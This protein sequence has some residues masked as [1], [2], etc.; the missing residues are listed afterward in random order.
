MYTNRREIKLGLN[1]YARPLAA[2]KMTPKNRKIKISERFI[3]PYWVKLS[4]DISF[5]ICFVGQVRLTIIHHY[6]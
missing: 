3:T 6:C 4:Q 5:S 1:L 2:T